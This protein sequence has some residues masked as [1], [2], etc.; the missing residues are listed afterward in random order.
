[1]PGDV[2]C[3]V[4]MAVQKPDHGSLRQSLCPRPEADR[5]LMIDEG[6][7]GNTM[8]PAART[9]ALAEIIFLAIAKTETSRVEGADVVQCVAPDIHA[10]ANGCRCRH[11]TAGIDHLAMRIDLI[12]RFSKRDGP[13]FIVRIAADCRIV[14][15]G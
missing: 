5:A 6:V 13:T 4:R 12:G 1:M 15:Q 8:L 7:A 11:E 9:G 2:R 10:E 14:R 3:V